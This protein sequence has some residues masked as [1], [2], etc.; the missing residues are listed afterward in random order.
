MVWDLVNP[1]LASPVPERLQE[2]KQSLEEMNE[3]VLNTKLHGKFVKKLKDMKPEGASVVFDEL[4]AWFPEDAVD[5]QYKR[6]ESSS[7]QSLQQ[8]SAGQ[9]TAAI[10]SFL[11]AHGSEPLLMDQPEDDLDNALVSQLV[12]NE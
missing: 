7:F 12:A 10:L 9:K 4:A 2:I 8:A 5:L 1:A 3:Q 11:L 6:D